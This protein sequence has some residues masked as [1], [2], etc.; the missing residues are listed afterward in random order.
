[1]PV[2]HFITLHVTLTFD[3]LTL[4]LMRAK[5]LPWSICVQS[6]MLIAEVVLLLERGQTETHKVTDGSVPIPTYHASAIAD[7]GNYNDNITIF[8][9]DLYNT[10]CLCHVDRPIASGYSYLLS[11]WVYSC[12]KIQ[13]HGRGHKFA[14]SLFSPPSMLARRAIIFA[15]AKFL[16]I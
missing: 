8:P 16:V 5:V 4:G 15:C 1:M 11:L 2:A 14:V 9:Q 13:L 6:L 3:L 10:N 7:M 12:L